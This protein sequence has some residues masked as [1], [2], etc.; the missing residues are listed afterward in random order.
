MTQRTGQP[1]GMDKHV[2]IYNVVDWVIPKDVP[3][4]YNSMS[5]ASLVEMLADM[6]AELLNGTYTITQLRHA[7]ILERLRVE[8]RKKGSLPDLKIKEA[9]SLV[10]KKQ[11]GENAVR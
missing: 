11:G 9:I 10:Q 4:I 7:I 5:V 6:I 1:Q 8:K 2:T 3:Q